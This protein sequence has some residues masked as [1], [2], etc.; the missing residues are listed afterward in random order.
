MGVVGGVG[1]GGGGGSVPSPPPPLL[2]ALRALSRPDQRQS[3]IAV[4]ER[5]HADQ[6]Y[7]APARVRR[8][9]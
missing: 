1:G 2:G 5:D 6:Q 4:S 7:G 3:S 9:A 8:R